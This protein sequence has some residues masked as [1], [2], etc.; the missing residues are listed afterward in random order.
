[1]GRTAVR[2]YGSC[3]SNLFGNVGTRKQ[4]TAHTDPLHLRQCGC[5]PAEASAQA[6][7][8][9]SPEATLK[10]P[11][12][13]AS[14]GKNEETISVQRCIFSA[15]ER[16]L[17]FKGF[18]TLYHPE[19]QLLPELKEK[20]KLN[21]AGLTPSQLF[22]EPPPRYTEATLVKTLEKYG[23]G[24]PS[25][26]API[27]STIQERGYVIK[28]ARQ[29][30]PT[31]LGILVNDKLVPFFEDVI[32]TS[33]T[34]RIEEELDL[35]EEAQ[36]DW[37]ETLKEFYEPFSKDLEK[38][39]EG[40]TSEKWKET[41]EKCPKCSS[42]VVERWSRFGKFLAC[43]GYPKCKYTISLK[44]KP[45]TIQTKDVCE[46]CGKPMVVKTSRSR[47]KFIAC[48]GY[49]ECKNTKPFRMPARET[50]SPP[51]ESTEETIT[52]E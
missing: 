31:E 50:G 21:L 25:T 29:L 8:E 12:R 52:E 49:P 36:K 11:C 22:T 33:F 28:N 4:K 47:R 40:M 32:N 20:D 16:R 3:G 39:Q 19:E 41:A 2:P 15:Q 37:I 24:R 44:P 27:I 7:M 26:Y 14:G 13:P 23:I 17:A 43:A 38:A 35:I 6:G 34:A 46:K 1:M 18:L 48:S 45:E 10:Q 42:A 51:P 9:K 30:L 5:L